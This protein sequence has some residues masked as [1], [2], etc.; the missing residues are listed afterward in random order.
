MCDNYHMK[1]NED[2][3]ELNLSGIKF[4]DAVK[5]FLQTPMPKDEKKARKQ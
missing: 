3:D 2:K 5:A 4:E 1:D